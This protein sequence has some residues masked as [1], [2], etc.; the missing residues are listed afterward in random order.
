MKRWCKQCHQYGHRKWLFGGTHRTH[1]L[2]IRW[3]MWLA[4]RKYQ[5]ES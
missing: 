5:R 1:R 2:Y 3:Q 4:R